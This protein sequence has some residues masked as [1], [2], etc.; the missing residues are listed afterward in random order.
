MLL[1]DHGKTDGRASLFLGDGGIDA[2]KGE[3]SKDGQL[4][5][6]Q[7]KYFTK[8][9]TDSQ[10]QK[11]RE[12][13]ERAS[14]SNDFTL[15]EWFLCIPVRPARQDLRWFDE[16][17]KKQ[18]V[19]IPIDLIDG[20][21]L[22]KMLAS[23]KGSRTRQRFRDWGVFT[24]RHGYPVIQAR[25]RC[26][27]PD[28]RT[29][30][31]FRLLV[32]IE[33]RGDRTADDIRVKVWHSDTH[34]SVSVSDSAFWNDDGTGSLNPRQLQAKR[35]L[36]PGESID[37]LLISLVPATPFPFSISV[38]CWLRDEGSSR[39]FLTFKD[40]QL[41]DGA[42]LDL[43]PGEI[44]INSGV[45][46]GY[47][48]STLKWPEDGPAAGLLTEIAAHSRPQEF[49]ILDFGSDAANPQQGNYRP[50]LAQSG[51]FHYM[52]RASLTAALDSLVSSRWLDPGEN[53]GKAT[54]YRLS[55]AGRAHDVFVKYVEQ[56]KNRIG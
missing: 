9:W 52:N 42:S 27:K 54:K 4:T 12:S 51:Q 26:R 49:G 43:R 36:H 11:I 23:E 45:D 24:V 46:G 56:Y 40:N 47:S 16:W 1:H 55:D 34:G 48:D 7:S 3:F 6:Y 21:D 18:P 38:E 13:F 2:Y 25:V 32:S 35:N 10:K 28:P 30:Q 41:S 44:T 17:R 14:Q 53:M 31:T 33:N 22:T 29:G 50:H 20:D 15:A 39:Q 8:V 37:T 19:P 5:V